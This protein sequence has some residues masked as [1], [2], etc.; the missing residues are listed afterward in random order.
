MK[1]TYIFLLGCFISVFNVLCINAQTE[2]TQD[3]LIQ[4]KL[5]LEKDYIPVVD[6]QERIIVTPET[7]PY[8]VTKRELNFSLDESRTSK[9]K[10][11]YNPLPVASLQN[12]TTKPEFGYIRLGVGSHR[13]FLGDGHINILHRKKNYLD[14]NLYHRSIFG[15]MDNNLGQNK[16]AVSNKNNI[17]INYNYNSN[18]YLLNA[19]IEEALYFWNYYGI[20]KNTAS[21]IYFKDPSTQ[22]SSDTKFT[23][24]I[25]SK[26]QGQDLLYSLYVEKGIY[27]LGRSFA[28]AGESV[29][30]TKGGREGRNIVKGNI[31]YLINNSFKFN[32]HADV[33][34]FTYRSPKNSATGTGSVYN[35]KDQAWIAVRPSLS[36]YY[37]KWKLDA[38]IKLN[39]PTLEH[40]KVLF[41]PYIAATTPIADHISFN[42]KLDGGIKYYSYT[43][44][45]KINPW[46]NPSERMRTEKTPVRIKAE[47]DI[48][49]VKTLRVKPFFSYSYTKHVSYF[50]NYSNRLIP[51]NDIN[52]S[53]GKIFDIAAINTNKVSFGLDFL[54]SYKEM[55]SVSGLFKYNIY[56]LS[57]N[58]YNF[59]KALNK[60]A[61]VMDIRTDFHPADK[62]SFYAQW[63]VRGL[64]YKY[65][66]NGTD[67]KMDNISCINIG[68]HY[69]I[70]N[71]IGIFINIDNLLDNRYEIQPNYKVHGFTAMIGG[72][73]NL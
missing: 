45:L 18:S 58:I 56:S 17:S 8:S 21:T 42:A 72:S 25:K 65:D 53:R 32:L 43:E 44:S 28:A 73:V 49:P 12:N 46:I 54:Q 64:R 3:T 55:I 9:V 68:G 1:S 13:S 63:N 60:P 31:A 50:Y 29:S 7:E 40:E 19:S 30:G 5:V 15:K 33:N 37:E 20:S 34:S 62:L 10:A 66:I 16:R 39:I 71:K 38:G 27:R 52:Y 61:F 6:K 57:D 41:S 35:F 48:K 4:R 22:W 69:K 67:S 59:D 36:F 47:L 23:F 14:A 24:G 51:I 26:N 2:E 70:N 11:D